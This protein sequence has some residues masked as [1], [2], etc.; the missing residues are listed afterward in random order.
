MGLQTHTSAVVLRRELQHEL[1]LSEG[2]SVGVPR[3]S[4]CS[5]NGLRGRQVKVTEETLSTLIHR[6]SGLPLGFVVERMV[7]QDSG[8]FGSSFDDP[9]GFDSTEQ[10]Q[11]PFEKQTAVTLSFHSML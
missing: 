7:S 2:I 3:N 8:D 1:R 5:V 10:F 6:S 4:R 11:L 9:F